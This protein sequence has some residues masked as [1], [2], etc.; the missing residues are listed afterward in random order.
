MYMNLHGINFVVA[1]SFCMLKWQ[2]P[3]HST[4]IRLGCHVQGKITSC[5]L[6][7]IYTYMYVTS[8]PHQTLLRGG[9]STWRQRRSIMQCSTHVRTVAW[10]DS[11]ALVVS[12]YC[13]SCQRLCIR[14]L[15]GS[16]LAL[17][18]AYNYI[19]IMATFSGIIMQGIWS[20]ARRIVARAYIY[21][22]YVT[23]PFPHGI[24]AL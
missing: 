15:A 14:R 4:C 24:T 18:F 8:L 3:C 7:I 11:C 6:R 13:M 19:N 22:L 2:H 12:Q 16:V 17:S 20:I 10:C 9:V 5:Y 21:I 1:C 23:W